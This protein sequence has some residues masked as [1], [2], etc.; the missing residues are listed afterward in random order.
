MANLI[1]RF[2]LPRTISTL[3]KQECLVSLNIFCV[4]VCVCVCCRQGG[5]NLS[6]GALPAACGVLLVLAEHLLEIS[7]SHWVFIFQAVGL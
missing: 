7:V 6:T 3:V 5:V 2:S 4:C 1:S